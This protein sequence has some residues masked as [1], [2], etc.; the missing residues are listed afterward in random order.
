MSRLRNTAL[1]A[2]TGLAVA[3]PSAMAAGWSSPVTIS[4]PHTFIGPLW[5]TPNYDNL[6]A[7]FNWQDGVDDATRVSGGGHIALPNSGAAFG[8]EHKLPADVVDVAGYQHTRL[9]ALTEKIVANPT[10]EHTTIVDVGYAK[11]QAGKAFEPVRRIARATV[12][13]QPVLGVSPSGKGGVIAYI[14]YQQKTRR[15]IVRAAIR[16]SSGAFSSPGVIS[17]QGQAE[18]VSAAAGDNGDLLVAFVRNGKLLARYRRHGHTWGSIQTITSARGGTH[19]D[20]KTA[21]DTRG[22]AEIVYRR[23][24]L[25]REGNP[26]VNTLEATYQPVGQ[27]HFKKPQVIEAEHAGAPGDLIDVPGGFAFAYAQNSTADQPSPAIPRVRLLTPAAGA[28]LDAAPAAGGVGRVRLAWSGG[29]GL[30]ATWVQQT[31]SGDGGGI[32][33]GAFAPSIISPAFGPATD[34]TPNEAVSDIAPG[35][36]FSGPNN[37]PIAVWV[38][39]PDGTGPGIP[40][41]QIKTVVRAAVLTQ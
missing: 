23:R 38:A 13:Y 12:L 32:G 7:A 17:G 41:A 11:G 22:R 1:L 25:G 30:F 10:R 31:P 27:S 35:F 2:L 24:Q 36:A 18:F 33:R 9:L 6:V 19:W 21:V 15:A 39:R 20:I 34:I 26:K 14:E 5:V 16:G 3:A 8:A 29:F 4:A 37:R 28:P 40:T